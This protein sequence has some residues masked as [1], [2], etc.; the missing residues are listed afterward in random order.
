LVSG[1]KLFSVEIF[2][3]VL[4]LGVHYGPWLQGQAISAGP[5]TPK[6]TFCLPVQ[7]CVYPCKDICLHPAIA[8]CSYLF[9]NGNNEVNQSWSKLYD[10][11]A[12][13]LSHMWMS[14]LSLVTW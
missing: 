13:Y 4:S 2:V 8:S 9:M 6:V 12:P 14:D 7:L 3:S 1:G 10:V 11:F 5:G